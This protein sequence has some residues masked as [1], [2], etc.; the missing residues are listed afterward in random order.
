[1]SFD[2]AD[3]PPAVDTRKEKEKGNKKLKNKDL[4]IKRLVPKIFG[5][6]EDEKDVSKKFSSRNLKSIVVLH[7]GSMMPIEKKT[8]NDFQEAFEKKVEVVVN[9]LGLGA[10]ELIE[11]EEK[12]RL[13]PVSGLEFYNLNDS[14][15]KFFSK[16]YNF[17]EMTDFTK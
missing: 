10:K 2:F 7:L 6:V 4:F 16:T 11:E 9:C 15:S 13:F 3:A 1:M 12:D 8:I 5:D 17:N 14:K